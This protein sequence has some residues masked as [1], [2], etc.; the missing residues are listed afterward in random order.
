MGEFRVHHIRF[1]DY[2]P[3]A[4]HCMCYEKK[5]QKL[6][7]SRSDGSIEIWSVKD[8]WFQEKVIRGVESVE[9][10]C[11]QNNRLF[12]AG[13]DGN[14]VEHDLLRLCPKIFVSSN[15]GPVWC[16]TTDSTNRYLAAGTEDGCVVLF[17]TDY[18]SLQILCIAWH[19]A[20]DVIVTGGVD[21]I[22]LWSVSSG[23][24]L[25]RLTLGRQEN[26][27]ET[28]VWC[29]AV[30]SD[31]TIVSGDSRGKMSFWNGKHGTLIKSFQSHVGD[32]LC[33]CV[34]DEEN[35]VLSSGVDT[36]TVRY[37]YLAP[38]AES[39]WKMWVR[40]TI[41]KHHT[42][43][44]RALAMIGDDFASGGVDTVLKAN[45]YKES[46]HKY[47]QMK[48]HAIPHLKAKTNNG[49]IICSAI[50][51][52]GKWLSYSDQESLKIYNL[53]M[54]S[55]ED[56]TPKVSL[57]KVRVVSH[58]SPAHQMAFTE[59]E[60]F[61][62]TTTTTSDIQIIKVEDN[63]A[64]LQDTLPASSELPEHIHLL[65]V[66][67]DGK[68]IATADNSCNVAIYSLTDKQLPR[69]SYQAVALSFT[70]S[71]KELVIAYADKKIYE[72]D[73][74]L[75]EYT[76]WCKTNCSKFPAQWLNRHSM[77]RNIRFD[78]QD[79]NKILLQDESLFTILDKTKPFPETLYMGKHRH[80]ST[81]PSQTDHAFRLCF[82]YKFLLYLDTLE[83]DW[84]VVVEKPQTEIAESL[85]PPLA[86][87]KFGI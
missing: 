11:W 40:S 79:S 17:D 49:Q 13:L 85:P 37:D 39:D 29:L 10:V 42:N 16:L 87:K 60:K 62:I 20:D 27:K 7:L 6:A 1:F 38:K 23:H 58:V 14:V 3:K 35:C 25:Q 76:D 21:S 45:I 48:L 55:K 24:A 9:A 64:V 4:I 54:D 68:L 34:N 81:D 53:S 28:I 43:D 26:N 51:R 33:L 19:A 31:M 22:R 70:P 83:D 5:S 44:V 71:C 8:K 47:R 77:V 36:A 52:D 82:R 18:N 74:Q 78:P 80:K 72:F 61:L 67:T 2:L 32:I 15:A 63:E 69:Y 75:G 66:S 30:T 84:L 73:V 41:I 65:T 12:S 50:S 46:E 59:D 56:I 57:K 86:Q